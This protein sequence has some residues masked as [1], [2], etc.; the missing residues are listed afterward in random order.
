M[1]VTARVIASLL[2]RTY[3]QSRRYGYQSFYCPSCLRICWFQDVQ[4][5]IREGPW[6]EAVERTTGERL[7]GV[8]AGR[9]RVPPSGHREPAGWATLQASNSEAASNRVMARVTRVPLLSWPQPCAKSESWPQLLHRQGRISH[10]LP[11][12]LAP[13]DLPRSP[14]AVDIR[15]RRPQS[16]FL[17]GHRLSVGSMVSWMS[18]LRS[19]LVAHTP[20]EDSSTGVTNWFDVDSSR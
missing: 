3:C 9:S 15:T 4:E 6:R 7:G 10:R 13:P 19:L 11:A 14:L 1:G 12:A 2:F 16:Y 8:P 18:G 20:R 17:L 5:Q